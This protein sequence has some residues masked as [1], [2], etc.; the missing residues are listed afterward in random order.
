MNNGSTLKM[1][2]RPLYLI[3]AFALWITTAHAQSGMALSLDGVDDRM[4]AADDPAL[5][6]DP[7]ESFTVTLWMKCAG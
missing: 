1:D 7:G 2:R 3:A 5:D 4:E 6:I